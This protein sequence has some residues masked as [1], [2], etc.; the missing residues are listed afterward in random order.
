MTG[1]RSS[2]QLARL[3]GI[4]IGVHAS[5]FLILFLLIF[6]FQRAFKQTLGDGSSTTAY[7]A[8]VAAAF[9]A[10]GSIVF[11]ELG[12]ALA[13]RREGLQVDGIDLFLFGGLMRMRSEP[14]TPGAE[15][16][17]AAAGP[18]GTVVV[19]LLGLAAGL[20]I[21]GATKLREAI[22]LDTGAHVSLGMQLVSTVVMLNVLL[23]AFNLIPAYP[24]DGGR[25]ARAI[26]WRVTGDR[27]RATRIA[28]T[29]G[30]GFSM[31]LFGIAIF[32]LAK[33]QVGNA[34]WFA[35][36]AWMLGQ[37]A[38]G[39]IVGAAFTER[40]EGITVADI[41][42]AEPVTIPGSLSALQ[43]YEDYFL[44][45]H[46][47]DWFAVVERD[48]RYLGR[49]FRS[50]VQEAAH[51]ANAQRPIR[52]VTGADAEGRVSDDAPL[53]ALVTSEPLRRLGALM[54]VDADGRLRGVVTFEQVARA[55]RARLATG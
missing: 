53:E 55:L 41:M 29:L 8:A 18:F 1:R 32:L 11:H 25:I 35:A 39:A 34:I 30:R 14:E 42:D 31:L 43:A 44:R 15:F 7:V 49:A 50:P 22:L 27:T 33:G 3:F 48:G 45:Y 37:S 23:L 10:F 12:H 40:L 4:R 46:G 6:F 24:L 28:A 2:L 38:R 36:I 16:R 17:V 51:G 20:A 13:A 9:L 52:E 19:I 26:I 54:A 5:W 47:W 21:G